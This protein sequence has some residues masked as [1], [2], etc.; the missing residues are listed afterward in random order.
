LLKRALEELHA[1]RHE[2]LNMDLSAISAAGLAAIG[3]HEEAL[4][5][6]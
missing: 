3:E 2:M 6:W 1:Q 5:L 4:T